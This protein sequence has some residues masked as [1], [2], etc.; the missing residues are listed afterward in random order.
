M[1]PSTGSLATSP[2]TFHHIGFVVASIQDSVQGFLQS[3]Q[4][5]W[6]AYGEEAFEYEILERLEDDVH[7]LAIAE[8]LKEMRGRWIA[9]L[10][11]RGI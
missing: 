3:L 9:R 11:A 10:G 5:E 2:A 4:A 1:E 6:D 8:R 7:P